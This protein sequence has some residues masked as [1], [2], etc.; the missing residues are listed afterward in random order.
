MVIGICFWIVLNLNRIIGQ[1]YQYGTQEAIT[2]RVIVAKCYQLLTDEV[3]KP[4]LV[5]EGCR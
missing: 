1:V 4:E 3:Q 2:W 5:M